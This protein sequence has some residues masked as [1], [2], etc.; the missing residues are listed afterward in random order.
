[1]SLKDLEP[2]MLLR[3][4]KAQYFRAALFVFESSDARRHSK[5]TALLFICHRFMAQLASA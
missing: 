2:A 4:F 1:M 5:T 3:G